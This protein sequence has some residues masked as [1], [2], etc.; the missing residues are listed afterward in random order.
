MALAAGR[1]LD[2]VFTAED[3]VSDDRVLFVSSQVN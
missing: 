3:L 1:D 2:R